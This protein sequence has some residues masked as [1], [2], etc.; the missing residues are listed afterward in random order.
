[1]VNAESDNKIGIEGKEK[2]K[3]KKR[4]VN[5]SKDKDNK[6]GKRKDKDIQASKESDKEITKANMDELHKKYSQSP[7]KHVTFEEE[8]FIKTVQVGMITYLKKI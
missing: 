1:M 7:K 6:K 5:L 8:E 2:T 3:K 4:E